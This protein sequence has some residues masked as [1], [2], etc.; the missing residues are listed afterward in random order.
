[1]LEV[2]GVCALTGRTKQRQT[3]YGLPCFFE[4]WTLF[5]TDLLLFISTLGANALLVQSDAAQGATV[6]LVAGGV[7]LGGGIDTAGKG[8]LGNVQ[9][10]FQQIIKVRS[11]GFS[12]P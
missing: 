12:Y 5:G 6:D 8:Q 9:L 2:P 11:S 10:I 3:K 7:F 4:I 1:M